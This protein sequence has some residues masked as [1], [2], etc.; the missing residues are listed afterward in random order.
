MQTQ[1]ECSVCFSVGRTVWCDGK[2]QMRRRIHADVMETHWL[3]NALSVMDLELFLLPKCFS[4]LTLQFASH[5]TLHFASRA[6]LAKLPSKIILVN[7]LW[8]SGRELLPL[9]REHFSYFLVHRLLSFQVFQLFVFMTVFCV[10]MVR[11]VIFLF[12]EFIVFPAYC[13]PLYSA[14]AQC[15][16]SSSFLSLCCSVWEFLFVF[17]CF[18]LIVIV[19]YYSVLFA[20]RQKVNT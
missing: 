18:H 20:G 6:N 2:V 8:Q 3:C 14:K 11:I 19:P 4:L 9:S 1:L 10:C 16:F 15:H 13:F 5:F 17:L 7:S 12:S